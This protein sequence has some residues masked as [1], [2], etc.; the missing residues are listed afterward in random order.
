MHLSASK[1]GLVVIIKVLLLMMLNHGNELQPEMQL[2]GQRNVTIL[3]HHEVPAAALQRRGPVKEMTTVEEITMEVVK[4]S[5]TTTT[6]DH[7]ETLLLL[8]NN[9]IKH[10]LIPRLLRIMDI[11][12][13]VMVLRVVVMVNN[14]QWAHHQDL[15]QT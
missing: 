3:G 2:H 12:H 11:L 14:Q 15:E 13:L 7:L 9:K 8:G 1:P 4:A 10:Q 6:P 5:K